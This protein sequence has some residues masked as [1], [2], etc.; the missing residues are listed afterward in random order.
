[1][2]PNSIS[3]VQPSF[4]LLIS[5]CTPKSQVTR[6]RNY[7]DK[8]TGMIPFNNLAI[9]LEPNISDV[10]CKHLEPNS[11]WPVVTEPKAPVSRKVSYSV[12]FATNKTGR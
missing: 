2:K 12:K 9:Y 8:K 5:L 4:H 7:R 11:L 6:L 3:T 1:M 10:L